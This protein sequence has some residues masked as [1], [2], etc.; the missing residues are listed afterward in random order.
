MRL[1]GSEEDTI[2]T[3]DAIFIPSQ[4]GFEDQTKKTTTTSEIIVVLFL[5]LQS[6]YSHILSSPSYRVRKQMH[7]RKR[8]TFQSSIIVID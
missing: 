3:T 5:S 2:L 8:L 4:N 7:V 6:L 1:A